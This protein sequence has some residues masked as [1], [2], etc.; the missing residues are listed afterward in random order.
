MLPAPQPDHPATL[1]LAFL[2]DARSSRAAA[3]VMRG[4]LAEQGVSDQELFACELC[5]AEACNNAIEYATGP[6]REKLPTA[7]AVCT[8]LQVELRVTDHTGGFTW[9]TETTIP[10]PLSERGRGLF[11]IRSMMDEVSYL[12]GA[13]ENVLIMRKTRRNTPGS[14]SRG[15]VPVSPEQLRHQ[16][17]DCKRTI[18]GMAREL[19]FRSETLSAV[20][21]CCAEM[22]RGGA[23]ADGFAQR[24]LGDLLH[25][26]V[27]DWYVMRLVSPDDG[28]LVAVAS[29]N[30]ELKLEPISLPG[31]G[32]I[33]AGSEATVAVQRAPTH[34]ASQVPGDAGDPLAA[35][36]P[37][38]HGVVYPLS[39]GGDFVGTIAVGRLSG[40]SAFGDLQ[41]EVV[42]TFAEFL[43]IQTVTI[44]HREEEVRSRVFAR[45]LE[46]GREIQRALLPVQLPQIPGF[47]LAGG[48][49]TA[50]EVGGDF[51]DAIQ[52]DDQSLLLFV[53]DVMG[54]GVPAAL[55]ATNI[56]G[57]LRG[58]SARHEDPAV[59]LNRLNTMLFPELS[60]VNMFITALV[61]HV[62]LSTRR[63]KVASA[64]HCPPLI[65]CSG[66]RP[67]ASMAAAGIPLGVL[68]DS[69]YRSHS[70]ALGKP[71]LLLLHTD[72]LTETRDASG[73][74]YG[75][76][77]LI[78][79]LH[80]NRPLAQTATELRDRLVVELNRYRGRAPMTDDQAF[81]LLCETARVPEAAA[82]RPAPRPRTV[83]RSALLPS[84]V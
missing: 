31:P 29:S 78:D 39:F 72:G 55:F 8:P 3:A 48:W 63:V 44:R 17:T 83:R 66:G 25:L 64:G 36:G 45:E 35:I 32:Q 58:L 37:E 22:G 69:K 60:A 46:I 24:L 34:F 23:V 28:T 84:Y 82:A 11:L 27:S 68:P 38:A 40:E 41:A 76:Q 73:R 67:V 50:R 20:F 71:G 52:L 53:A 10:S 33:P 42:R 56:R 77:G 75:Q 4:F 18:A 54:K 5:L 74:M 57:L 1:R 80:A 16:L 6:G 49:Q 79:W 65:S 21:R 14:P 26:T 15:I 61:A 43:A 51:Y 30:P 81:L 47:S 13:G 19:C 9:P 59:L 12:R 70:A 62:D 2:P 7:E